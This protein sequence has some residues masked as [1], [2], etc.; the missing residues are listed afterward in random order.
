MKKNIHL[1]L[2]VLF[3][4][5]VQAQIITTIAGNGVAACSGDGGPATAACTT[6]HEVQFDAAGNLFITDRGDH[7]IRKV[8]N[9]GIITTVAGNGTPGFSGDG[10][11]ATNA[12]LNNPNGVAIDNWGT[13][14]IADG[15]NNRIRKVDTF[16]VIT[17]IVGT[18]VTG[19]GGDGSAATNAKLSD[20]YSV[21]VDNVGNIYIADSYN[22][23]I[24]KVNPAGIISTIVGTGV[25]GFS[26][27]GG[28][29]TAAML[30]WPTCVVLDNS[31]NI[32]ISDASN[33]RIRKIDAFGIISTVAG[34]GP[35]GFSAG[36]FGGDT[37]PATAAIF[38]LPLD[39]AIDGCGD[40]FI[41][42]CVNNRVRKVDGTG[43]IN[44][45]AGNGT[46]GFMGDGSAATMAELDKPVGIALDKN[47]NLVIADNS[48][49]HIRMVSNLVSKP[50]FING[51]SSSVMVCE[52][53]PA[54]PID[55][56]LGVMDLNVG[57][58]ETWSLLRSPSHGSTSIVYSIPITG[59]SVFPVGLTYTPNPGYVG[60]D[61]F[62]VVASDCASAD[63]IAI[64]I[65]IN[66]SPNVGLITG[67]P[68]LCLNEHDTAYLADTSVGGS[69][70]IGNNSVATLAGPGI[71][72]GIM[73]GIDT[74]YYS[75]TNSDDECS[76][77]AAFPIHIEV[78]DGINTPKT[79]A[80]YFSISPNPNDGNFVIELYAGILDK[81]PV[82]IMNALGQKIVEKIL[83]PGKENDIEMSVPPGVY[84]IRAYFAT[85]VVS[86][87]LIIR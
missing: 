4:S 77:S 48:S 76:A 50:S 43:L 14:Y 39:I 75:V 2:C 86:K 52:G 42:D 45:I 23:C 32:F 37:G 9:A 73:P 74:I 68:Y 36:G 34:S 40:L 63:T 61:T 30:D 59:Y 12:E 11:P 62:I 22:N 70:S 16:G 29:A 72:Y 33:N 10:G 20:P 83:V 35:V 87:Q 69:W 6:V 31:G 19:Y 53:S 13:M 71:V 54:V 7:R 21:A 66:P 57:E 67:V 51:S 44:T 27:D 17:T 78:C 56:L 5:T 1:L 47:S 28:A 84:V 25:S 38:N 79:R 15:P 65:A 64:Y 60:H 3:A 8:N 46:A 85:G 49:N 18:G 82:V 24:R 80:D 55:S 81:I 58:T 26:G 41:S